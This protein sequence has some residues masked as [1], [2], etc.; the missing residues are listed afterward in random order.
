MDVIT[1]F[2]EWLI[3]AYF[4]SIPFIWLWVF[5]HKIKCR[6]IE[7]CSNRKCKYWKYCK[8]NYAERKKDEL[9]LRKQ[10]LQDL[11]LRQTAI[12]SMIKTI[13]MIWMSVRIFCKHDMK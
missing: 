2:F 8:H 3:I 13:L 7:E 1:N 11:L 5:Y 10:M 12:S 6:K 9:E 4:V